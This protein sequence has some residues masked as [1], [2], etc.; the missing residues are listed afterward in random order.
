MNSVG[1]D[2]LPN[3]TLAELLEQCGIGSPKKPKQEVLDGITVSE[4][5]LYKITSGN[6]PLNLVGNWLMTS[7]VNLPSLTQPIR[8]TV[9]ISSKKNRSRGYGTGIVVN[10]K[11][12]KYLVTASHVIGE[13]MLSG[14]DNDLRVYQ[15]IDDSE[16]S[17]PLTQAN[18]I[19]HSCVAAKKDLPRGDVAV[20]KYN[21]PIAGVEVGELNSEGRTQTFAIGFPGLHS[22]RWSEDLE[23]L[24]SF[25]FAYIIP[26]T[27][28]ANSYID[29]LLAKYITLHDARRNENFLDEMIF[30]GITSGGNSGGGI[31]NLNGEILGVCRGFEIIGCKITENKVF[32]SIK[33]LLEEIEK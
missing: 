17:F 11:E 12:K 29:R 22:D 33:Q 27:K 1:L 26:K 32:F 5:E 2:N 14:R 31:F 6:D 24:L 19:C 4:G 21:G 20:F 30:T 9:L 18:L 16:H 28:I 15:K 23:P 7:Q 25:G 8:S 13:E 10:H 3:K